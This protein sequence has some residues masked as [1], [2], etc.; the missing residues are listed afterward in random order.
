MTILLACILVIL[1]IRTLFYGA[2]GVLSNPGRQVVGFILFAAFM[3]FLA[4][5]L[6]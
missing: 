4:I 6:P 3:V 1:I 2:S 5:V